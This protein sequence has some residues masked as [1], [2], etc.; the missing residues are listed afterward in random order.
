MLELEL[1]QLCAVEADLFGLDRYG[2]V[3]YCNH[4]KKQWF[5]ISMDVDDLEVE[6]EN[7]VRFVPD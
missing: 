4:E 6:N 3:W 1:T 7:L 2:G 5:P